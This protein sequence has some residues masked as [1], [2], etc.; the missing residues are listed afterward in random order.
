[1]ATQTRPTTAQERLPVTAENFP[2]AESDLYFGNVVKQG[3]FGKFHHHREP[4]EINNQTVIRMNRD[5]LYS[6]GG[7]RSRRRTRHHHAARC[8]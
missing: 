7:I 1:M 8:R 6:S 5:T 4:A 3:G 2:S